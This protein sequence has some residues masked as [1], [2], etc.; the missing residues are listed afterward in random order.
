V[1]TPVPSNEGSPSL[2][3]VYSIALGV[4]KGDNDL[5]VQLDEALTHR[6]AEIHKILQDYGVPFT[7]D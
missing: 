7:Q 2:P 1:L 5:R 3:L 4:R 6:A